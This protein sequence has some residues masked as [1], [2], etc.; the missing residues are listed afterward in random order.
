VAARDGA[1]EPALR[2]MAEAV[3]ARLAGLAAE[4]R[5]LLERALTVQRRVIG[6]LAQAVPR[7]LEAAPRY[8]AGGGIA[9]RARPPPVVL[10]ARV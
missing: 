1:I 6:A 5:R 7:A 9:G 2:G 4:N 10:A 3:G 8:D